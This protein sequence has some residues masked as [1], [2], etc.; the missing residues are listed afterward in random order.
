[1]LTVCAPCSYEFMCGIAAKTGLPDVDQMD[2]FCTDI[3]FEFMNTVSG[4]VVSD[5]DKYG[6]NAVFAPPESGI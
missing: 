6:M 2:D 5:W 3:L 1:M 4:M